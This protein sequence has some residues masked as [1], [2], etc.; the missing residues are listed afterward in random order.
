MGVQ[1]LWQGLCKALFHFFPSKDAVLRCDVRIDDPAM[2]YRAEKK[3][4]R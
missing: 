3:L 4:V 2:Q 1:W